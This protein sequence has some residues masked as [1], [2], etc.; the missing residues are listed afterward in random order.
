MTREEWPEKDELVVCTVDELKTF[1]AFVK[2]EEYE[3]KE[4]LIHISAVSPGWVKHLRDHV[5]EGQK[6]V[7]KV[8]HVDAQK[9][10]S[11]ALTD[12][13][14]KV[15]ISNEEFNELETKLLDTYESLYDAFED[16][17][18]VG[19]KALIAL[20]LKEEHADAIHEMACTN[21]KPPSVEITGYVELKC[22]L[23]N[24]IEIIKEALRK[25]EG[26]IKKT[27]PGVD[28]N[29]VT[30]E[31]IYIGAPKYK[32]RVTASDFKKAE[33]VLSD[34]ASAAI[35]V[36]KRNEGYGKFYRNLP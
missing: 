32:M 4:G 3:G 23:S 15:E 12:S 5:R 25:A 9:W 17:V 2:L 16:V 7:C 21:V 24:G 18:T 14:S 26:V 36:I 33:G 19:K 30:V 20:G 28:T 13:S 29:G 8:L 22:P 31:C 11:L 27:A 10:L 34:A 6:I 1:G 35:E